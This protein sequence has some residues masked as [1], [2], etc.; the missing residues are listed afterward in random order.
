MKVSGQPYASATSPLGKQP[1]IPTEQK[2]AWATEPVWTLAKRKISL[3]LP[4]I[5]P[6]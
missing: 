5:E 3:P 2:A 4:G 6:R 1:S